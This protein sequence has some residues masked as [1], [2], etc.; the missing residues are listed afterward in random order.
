AVREI[1]PELRNLFTKVVER[2][3]R[4]AVKMLEPYPD[5]FVVKM[6]EL[7]NPASA[8]NILQRS[9]S[10]RRQT[11]LATASVEDTQQWMR[12]Q[13]YPERTIGRFDAAAVGCFPA[14]NDR[15][16]S[17][18]TNS[19]P[20]QQSHYNLRLCH[21]RSGET[22]WGCCDARPATGA[23][24]SAAGRD[25]AREPVLSHTGHVSDRSDEIRAGSAF[26][27]LSGL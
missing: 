19:A 2:N 1:E 25:H 17:N 14:A 11:V 5:E 18:R 9:D 21:R 26:S 22:P 3:P 4:E 12:N 6:L 23:K 13:T 10:A 27:G 20:R 15:C 16:R 8:L 24:H 7:L